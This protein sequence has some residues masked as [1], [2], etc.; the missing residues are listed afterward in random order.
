MCNRLELRSLAAIF[1][2]IDITVID[3]CV[4]TYIR[5]R[6]VYDASP[7]YYGGFH[8]LYRLIFAVLRDLLRDSDES[9]D[10]GR[11]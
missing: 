7:F 1:E 5:E 4:Y 2:V 11:C 8:D 9:L 10:A 6:Y 3:M